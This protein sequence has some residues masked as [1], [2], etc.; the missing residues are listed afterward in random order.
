[1]GQPFGAFEERL[2]DSVTPID[3]PFDDRVQSRVGCHKLEFVLVTL[4]HGRGTGDN[5][6]WWDVQYCDRKRCRLEGP[7]L[8]RRCRDD[9]DWQISILISMGQF[10]DVAGNGLSLPVAPIDF[11]V[12]DRIFPRI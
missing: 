6:R 5:N 10:A 9:R 1:M 2:A 3:R 11:P 7:V 8:I 12:Q 4:V